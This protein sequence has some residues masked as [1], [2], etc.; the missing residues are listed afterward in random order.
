MD[1][2]QSF[3]EELSDWSGS[4]SQNEKEPNAINKHS[5]V[6]HSG[7][8]TLD[9]GTVYE[10]V[11]ESVSFSKTHHELNQGNLGTI[12]YPSNLEVRKYQEEIV[13]KAV[14][15]NVLCSLPTGLGKTFI[16]ATV[17]LNFYRWV[18]RAKIIFMAPT[19]P[20]VAQQMR[21]CYGIAGLPLEDTTVLVGVTRKDRAVLWETRRVFFST[22]QMVANDLLSGLVDP[23]N[24]C[25]VVVDEAH[26]ARGGSYAYCKVV[27]RLDKLNT[28]FRVLALT[29]TPGATVES[30]QKVVDNLDI[31]SIQLRTDK[32]PDVL[33]YMNSR[34]LV[35]IDCDITPEIQHAVILISEA[36]L[37]V[38]KRA[39]SAG[40]YDITDPARINQF[41]ALEKSRAVVANHRLPEGLKWTYFFILRLLSE[42]GNFFRRL[43][44]YGI[45]TFYGFFLDK[46]TEFTTKYQ[47]K[48][49]TNK[50]AASFY[51][52]PQI[53]ELKSY[54]EKLIAED[55]K[56]SAN[57]GLKV[58]AGTFSHTKFQE[59]VKRVTTFLQQKE[60]E[61]HGNS[62]IIVFTEFR[63]NALEIVRCLESANKLVSSADSHSKDL[64]RPHIFIGQAKEKSRFDEETFRS[65]KGRKKKKNPKKRKKNEKNSDSPLATRLGSS[66]TAQAKGMS[67]K[68]QKELLSKFKDGVYNVLVATSIGEEGLDIGEVDMIVCFDST[69]SPIKNIQRMGRTGRKR[70]GN[71]VML[72]S[73]N[74]REKF[75]R[76]M[77][78]YRWIQNKIRSDDNIIDL[79]PSD[80]IFPKEY[81]PALE[82]RKIT[83]PETNKNLL[84][85]NGEDDD[86][87]IEEAASITSARKNKAKRKSRKRKKTRK[88]SDDDR[89]M[90]LTK[91]MFMP[92]NA[93]T[94]FRPA[95]SMIRKVVS[96]KQKQENK[97][98]EKKKE[99][100][101]EKADE[102]L[103]SDEVECNQ[104]TPSQLF[105]DPPE[106]T[107]GKGKEIANEPILIDL[108]QFTDDELKND[109]IG[110]EAQSEEISEVVKA[111]SESK[112]EGSDVQFRD[113]TD[114]KNSVRANEQIEENESVE[115]SNKT[116]NKNLF[117]YKKDKQNNT[118]CSSKG[119]GKSEE[120]S[121]LPSNAVSD[122]FAFKE[123]VD[124]C[125]QVIPKGDAIF[126]MN[127]KER[128]GFM[129]QREEMEFYS[130]YFAD[131]KDLYYDPRRFNIIDDPLICIKRGG[132]KFGKV[133]HSS[134]SN[135]MIEWHRA[136][137]KE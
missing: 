115:I 66:E 12:I 82:Y 103:L 71:V 59:L 120:I 80:R 123:Q 42:V 127:F 102:T 76:A 132:S 121:T 129:S 75:A 100:E 35:E 6:T 78:N 135:M 58:V 46:Y 87:F 11:K 110:G 130:K 13:K 97:L 108:S 43:N 84:D 81:K 15:E 24:V 83:I 39:N 119:E 56:N 122:K 92:E 85:E 60:H 49:S 90:K 113:V 104:L 105:S 99:K 19:R 29:A 68:D 1:S 63:D 117:T 31:S 18:E 9:G 70:A 77:D 125:K 17:M 106:T 61:S 101:L 45:V 79:H 62:S 64:V 32:D 126:N 89:Q 65:T 5:H 69:S 40:I 91:K 128:E 86:A 137:Q 94:G 55:S 2:D 54:I 124:V 72:F 22:P 73:S 96:Q 7:Q 34:S 37:P 21:A 48:K 136:L 23:R 114:D 88:D 28:S 50:L 14:M 25:C 67:Q 53:S 33:Q 20:L 133:P 98:I 47:M 8:C 3:L 112:T 134:A 26:R 38:L 107:N 41:M 4:S 116:H 44:V 111:N 57:P 36:I 30:V 95:S 16:A 109:D 27:E 51:F 131:D 74:E 93:H 10:E 118:I 52:S